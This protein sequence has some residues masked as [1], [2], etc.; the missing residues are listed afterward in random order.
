VE[1]RLTFTSHSIAIDCRYRPGRDRDIGAFT[2]LITCPF[3]GGPGPDL[4]GGIYRFDRQDAVDELGKWQEYKSRF[5]SISLRGKDPIQ[6]DVI[7]EG[8]AW[9]FLWNDKNNG[10]IGVCDRGIRWDNASRKAGEVFQLGL[11]ARF[12][13]SDGTNF[14]ETALRIEIPVGDRDRD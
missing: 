11:L 12:A 5:S 14:P 3:D 4:V 6:L 9:L 2:Y 7:A 1:Q 8:T 13:N 10:F